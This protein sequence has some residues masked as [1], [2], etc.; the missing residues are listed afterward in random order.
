VYVREGNIPAYD[1]IVVDAGSGHR[2]AACR[3]RLDHADPDFRKYE[4]TDDHDRRKGGAMVL[5]DA[6]A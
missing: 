5:E 3:G 1:F 6:A 2:R 4:C